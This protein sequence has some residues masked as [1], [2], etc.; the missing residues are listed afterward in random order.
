M[1]D[2]NAPLDSLEYERFVE[3]SL[4]ALQLTGI[5][6]LSSNSHLL[7]KSGHRHQIDI[8]I[9]L[10]IVGIRLLVLIECKSYKRPVEVADVLEL[11][12]RLDDIGA[13]KGVM[14]TTIGYQ[15]GA[16]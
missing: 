1:S 3:R 7:G 4:A 8:L 11:I 15:Q 9:E 13:H 12:G 5:G 2:V 10:T 6:R 14:V 16:V